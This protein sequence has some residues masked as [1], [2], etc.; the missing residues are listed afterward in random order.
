MSTS[1]REPDVGRY[2]QIETIP[3]YT[4][5]SP[6]RR[7]YHPPYRVP[8]RCLFDSPA[9]SQGI[10]RYIATAMAAEFADKT[11]SELLDKQMPL[12]LGAVFAIGPE[13]TRTI[14]GFAAKGG[15]DGYIVVS[16]KGNL[17]WKSAERA[18]R[19]FDNQ[20]MAG[21]GE[22][23]PLYVQSV[24]AHAQP[25]P[26]RVERVNPRWIDANYRLSPLA[27]KLARE[28]H[29]TLTPAPIDD[30]RFLVGVPLT[31]PDGDTEILAWVSTEVGIRA[32][33]R[34][35]DGFTVSDR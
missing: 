29:W 23:R 26:D 1:S 27:K 28:H 17:A 5:D 24:L 33:M 20:K 7:S 3:A 34:A 32:A 25:H 22:T 4:L 8:E 16:E 15:K 13:S 9:P 2:W 12:R 35:G 10:H 11:G 21:E 14:I 30:N 19:E 18:H 31:G 6:V